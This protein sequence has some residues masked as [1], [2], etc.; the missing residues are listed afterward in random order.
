MFNEKK[1]EWSTKQGKDIDVWQSPKYKDAKTKAME[2]LEGKKYGLSEGDF[3]ILMNE[4]KSGKMG[5]TGLIISHNGCLKINDGLEDKLKFK[6]ECVKNEIN[7]YKGELVFTYVC[8]EQGIY[9]VGEVSDKNCKNEYPYAMGIKRCMDR[10]ILKNCKLAYNGV[11]SDSEAEEFS[12]KGKEIETNEK[13][14]TKEDPTLLE[15]IDE[16]QADILFQL[17]L[18]K[19]YDNDDIAKALSKYKVEKIAEL[20]KGQYAEILMKIK[21]AVG[22]KKGGE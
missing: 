18:E 22:K 2:L 16:G 3:W 6:P 20:N 7:G 21:S 15:K 19:G 8:P 12:G 11:Y 10:V 9:E 14:E 5:Y 13:A 17:T 1:E 4:T